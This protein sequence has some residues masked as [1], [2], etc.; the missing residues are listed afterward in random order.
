MFAYLFSAARTVRMITGFSFGGNRKSKN[1]SRTIKTSLISTSQNRF[2]LI[3]EVFERRFN[4][5]SV[6]KEIMRKTLK[7][8][9]QHQ[10]DV[11]SHSISSDFDSFLYAAYV[12]FSSS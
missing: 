8:N 5:I 11:G 9:N 12:R 7:Q 4:H 2:K 3:E 10:S 6:W 1:K